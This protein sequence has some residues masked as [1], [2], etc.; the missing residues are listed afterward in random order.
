LQLVGLEDKAARMP[1]TLSG[2]EQQRVAL[3]RALA[4]RPGIVL[5]DEPFSSLDA[6]LR[7]QLRDEV[8][9]LLTDVGVTAVLVTH[10]QQEALSFGDRVAV[11]NSGL[12]QHVGTPEEVYATPANRWVAGF[13]GEAVLLPAVGTGRG[14]RRRSVRSR[15]PPNSATV[16]RC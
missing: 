5:L 15:P 13:V 10:D 11:M 2:G 6:S 9:R 4:P 16:A 8:R 7:A 3:A 12:V 1:G 14:C